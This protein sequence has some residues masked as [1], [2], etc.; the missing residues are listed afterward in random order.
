MRSSPADD[1]D[2]LGVGLVVDGVLVGEVVQALRDAGHQG[3]HDEQPDRA[4]RAEQEQQARDGDLT[5]RADDELAAD[6]GA[7]A[8]RRSRPRCRSAKIG[9][10]TSPA[11]RPTARGPPRATACSRRAGRR[12]D[13]GEQRAG[14]GGSSG[15][16]P[17][18]T[19]RSRNGVRGPQLPR[20]RA[21]PPAATRE[22]EQVPAVCTTG[23]SGT[24][25]ALTSM[26]A[27]SAIPARS[28]PRAR[29]AVRAG[30]RAVSAAAGARG[31]GRPRPAGR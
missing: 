28:T 12:N 22:R 3:D 17:P 21:R 8:G 5:D 10:R 14:V 26:A 30:G 2:A 19:R 20:V 9:S 11:S 13:R 4:A 16:L 18:S 29:L 1:A 24:A 27:N 23:P 15:R 6:L 25:A 7:A 31:T